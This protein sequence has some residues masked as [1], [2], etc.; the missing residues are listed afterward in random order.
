MSENLHKLSASKSRY[1]KEQK[2]QAVE[3]YVSYKITFVQTPITANID[4]LKADLKTKKASLKKLDKELVKLES[5]KKDAETKAAESAK[6]AE[7]EDVLKK[8]LASGMTADEIL[9]KL[10]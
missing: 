2:I 5:K 6:K 3:Y 1:T 9:A 7:A 10:K 8:L 4:A